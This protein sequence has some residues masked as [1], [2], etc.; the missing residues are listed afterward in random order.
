MI[1]PVLAAASFS[2][3]CGSTVPAGVP[4][5]GKVWFGSSWAR[6]SGA[7]VIVGKRSHFHTNGQ[8]AWVAHFDQNANAPSV[9][10]EFYSVNSGQK[11]SIVNQPSGTSKDTNEKAS[12]IPVRN[13][14]TAGATRPGQ[15]GIEYIKGTHT[16]ASGVFTLTK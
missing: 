10:F 13:L 4:P 5:S 14:I 2:A 6:K 1:L 9:M 12:V 16:L 7:L 3:S 11:K 15:Y 8:I